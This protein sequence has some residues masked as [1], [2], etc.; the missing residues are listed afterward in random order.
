M[1][2]T[3]PVLI[4]DDFSTMRKKIRNQ[5][6]QLGFTSVS[7]ANSGEQALH[8]LRGSDFKLII[9]DWN[10]PDMMGLELLKEVRADIRLKDIPFLLITAA[11]REPE[12]LTT[13]DTGISRWITKPF[14]TDALK[15][16]IDAMLA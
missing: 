11:S 14:D 1:D 8:K 10:M 12:S 3:I 13:T 2:H 7:E 5:L 16:I 6:K 15:T 9:S 4:V